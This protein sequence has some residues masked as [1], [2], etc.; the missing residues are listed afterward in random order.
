MFTLYNK[1]SERKKPLKLVNIR[2]E[3]SFASS[4]SLY[5]LSHTVCH[6]QSP[7]LRR[8]CQQ[9]HCRQCC[10]QQEQKST[11]GVTHPSAQTGVP[12]YLG[13]EKGVQAVARVPLHKHEH[14]GCCL[15][16]RREPL[17]VCGQA[18]PV[19]GPAGRSEKWVTYRGDGSSCSSRG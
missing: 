14:G 9:H 12:V 15:W 17:P 18:V 1:S 11:A 19:I 4:A 13:K 10:V 7:W 3:V 2:C 8:A 6:V 5:K 16:R